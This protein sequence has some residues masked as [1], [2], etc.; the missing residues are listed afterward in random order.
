MTTTMTTQATRDEALPAIAAADGVVGR[1]G[2]HAQL[3]MP[4]G[5]P[6][7]PVRPCVPGFEGHEEQ[8]T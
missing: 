1:V 6:P 5:T 2:G 4:T 7:R 8:G 3:G